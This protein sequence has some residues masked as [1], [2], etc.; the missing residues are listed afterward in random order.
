VASA[1]WNILQS[2]ATI[3]ANEVVGAFEGLSNEID[4]VIKLAQLWWTT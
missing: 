2:V 1:V 3:I 4:L